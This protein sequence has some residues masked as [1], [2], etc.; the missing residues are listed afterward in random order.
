MRP[1][2]VEAPLDLRQKLE[3][4]HAD[5][6]KD[7]DAHQH[8]IRVEGGAGLRD[9]LPD[10]GLRD[11]ELGDE[12]ADQRAAGAQ[13]KPGKDERHRRR[14]HDGF[15]DL[16]LRRLKAA[17]G[18]DQRS[19]RRLDRVARVHDDR[20]NGRHEDQRELRG[21]ADAHPDHQQ[22]QKG[23]DRSGVKRVQEGI[24]R[25]VEAPVPAERDPE[26]H[27]DE[28]GEEI[29]P[30]ELDAADIEVMN[31]FPRLIE[32][33]AGMPYAR[34]RAE[35]DRIGHGPD[36]ARELPYRDEHHDGDGA[37]DL[38]LVF[39]VEA[40]RPALEPFIADRLV[41]VALSHDPRGPPARPRQDAGAGVSDRPSLPNALRDTRSTNS[42]IFGSL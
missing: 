17:G 15:E 26:W 22:R 11:V 28:D 30:E 34:R 12:H 39:Q 40:G 7:H 3:C 24:E 37:Q 18:L 32:L 27:A 6:G 19:R 41:A 33:D 23:D 1:P 13:A 20:E 35:E 25:V 2:L 10:A 8:D 38:L 36:A 21:D 42:T 31:Q 14:Q 16:V 5:D 29:A 9:H 4:D